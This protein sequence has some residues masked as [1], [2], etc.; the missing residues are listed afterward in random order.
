MLGLWCLDA[1]F[2]S[3]ADAAPVPGEENREEVE[4]V[5]L[6]APRKLRQHLSRANSAIEEQRYGDA[7]SELGVLLASPELNQGGN[8]DGEPQDFFLEGRTGSGTQA[9]LKTE[10]QRLLGAMPAR[11]RELYE[12][13]FGAEAKSLL[14]AATQSGDVEKLNEVARRYFHTRAGYE[15]T[16]LLGRLHFDRGRPLAAALCWKRVLAAPSGGA[17]FDPELP[18]MLAAAYLQANRSDD[19]VTEIRGLRQRLPQTRLQLGANNSVP[20]PEEG[21]ELPWLETHFVSSHGASRQQSIG[22][23]TIYRGDPARNAAAAGDVPLR[24]A[25]WQVASVTDPADERIIA[26]LRQSLL[27]DDS[28][29]VPTLQP[30]AVDNLVLMRSAERLVALDFHTGKRIWEYPWWQLGD[31]SSVRDGARE[32]AAEDRKL[33]LKQ[34]L[35]Y[36]AAYGQLSSDGE[37]VFQLDEL[38]NAL[39]IAARWGPGILGGMRNNGNAPHNQLVALDLRREGAQLWMVGGETGLDE[40]KLAGAFFL[41]APLPLFGQLYALVELNAEIRLVVLD[42]RT[43]RQEWSQQLAHVDGQT[44]ADNPQRRLV[45]ASPSFADGVVVCPT[46]G[47]AVVAVDMATRSLLWGFQYAPLATPG[48]SFGMIQSYPGQVPKLGSRWLDGT[49]TVADGA[50]ILT[51]PESNKLFCLDLLTGE[52]KWPPRERSDDLADMLYVACV[53]DGLLVLVGRTRVNALS[54]RDGQPAW[55]QPVILDADQQEMPSGRGYYSEKYYYLPTTK[56]ELLQIDLNQGQI[57]QRVKTDRTLGNLICHQDQVIGLGIDGLF[58]YHQTRPLRAQVTERLAKSPADPWA[59]ARQGELLVNDGDV[60]GALLSLREAFGLRP[61]DQEVRGLLVSTFLMALEDDFSRNQDLAPAMEPLIDDPAHR[62]TYLRILAEGLQAQGRLPEAW[63]ALSRLA[64]V[65]L[66]A[67][68]DAPVIWETKISRDAGWSVRQDC[69]FQAKLADLTSTADES[70]QAIMDAD[71]ARRLQPALSA[72]ADELEHFVALFGGHAQVSAAHLQLAEHYVKSNQ[73][74]AAELELAPLEFHSAPSVGGAATARLAKIRL[75][76]GDHETA[77]AGYRRVRQHWPDAVC[78]DGKTGT[79]LFDEAR[80]S[81]PLKDLLDESSSAWKWG[82]VKVEEV[83]QA[84]GRQSYRRIYPVPLTV[85]RGSTSR[86]ASL[87]F[88]TGSAAAVARDAQGKTVFPVK[89]TSGLTFY[90]QQPGIS[91]AVALGNLLVIQVADQIAAVDG[92]RA[93]LNEA[94]GVL[95]RESLAPP[96]TEFNQPPARSVG[97][98]ARNP[99]DPDALQVFTLA[100]GSDRPLGQAGPVTYRGVFYQKLRT[101]VCA[102]PLTGQ[103]RWSRSDIPQGADL[104]GDATTLFAVDAEGR[105]GVA[106]SAVDGRVLKRFT[107]PGIQRR[108]TTCGG[109]LLSW[110]LVDEGVRLSLQDLIADVTI[111]SETFAEGARGC[112][113]GSEAVA[114]CETDGHLVIRSL[115][116]GRVV[117][118][119]MLQPESRLSGL[120]VWAYS[121]QLLVATSREPSDPVP[122]RVGPPADQVLGHV[123]AFDRRSGESLWQTPAYIDGYHRPPSQP[124]DSPAL[125]FLRQYASNTVES[126]PGLGTRTAILCLDRRTGRILLKKDE[127]QSQANL[128][129]ILVD[130]TAQT[131][132]LSIPGHTFVLTFTDEPIPPEPSAQTGSASST[133][134]IPPGIMREFADSMR[135]VLMSGTRAPSPFDD[136]N[137]PAAKPLE[138]EAAPAKQEDARPR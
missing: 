125:W 65:L 117:L 88:D 138:D 131:S 136:E 133:A 4:S 68:R 45:G 56:A 103:V 102:D 21:Q 26:D 20:L 71:V 6:P 121:D 25:R 112:L 81:A 34:R 99:L 73:W 48:R 49:V 63:A 30:L 119:G 16:V 23:W 3:R 43:G 128:H 11:G 18:V 129:D 111:W 91:Q 101:L 77:A 47:G 79:Q 50:V 60:R 130:R 96:V 97:R 36:D 59:L 118:D 33:K 40:P 120:R 54:L 100:D 10:A 44:V 87:V 90:S 61:E 116:D 46:S 7:V 86:V 98:T 132:T 94:E 14:D 1:R 41:G 83:S 107:V 85:S 64:D 72:S 106:L 19:A 114:V 82:R 109:N 37:S 89:F 126:A 127:L 39:P 134:E 74:L 108:W 137:P 24:T 42:S 52:P 84:T 2:A 115:S 93:A 55:S 92:L 75:L 105:S 123:Y 27:D 17:R 78:C 69:W 32:T 122:A 15:A 58:A 8:S 22:Q 31:P 12:L 135:H 113:V 5:F 29:T 80:S 62:I 70:L 53:H 95:W 124:L 13:Q 35:W 67:G 66:Q 104:F 76:A 51:P 38:P 9:S 57:V 110:E 28:P